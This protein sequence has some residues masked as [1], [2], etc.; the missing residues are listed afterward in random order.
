[1]SGIAT[2]CGMGGMSGVGRMEGV[3]G[4][5]VPFNTSCCG[6]GA[7]AWLAF[8]EASLVKRFVGLLLLG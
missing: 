7:C 5:W 6:T 8:Q 3:G 4:C 2:A 1:M